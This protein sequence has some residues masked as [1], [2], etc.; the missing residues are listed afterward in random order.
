MQ[1][2]KLD[3]LWLSLSRELPDP[4]GRILQQEAGNTVQ[5]L[6][7]HVLLNR[8]SHRGTPRVVSR[9]EKKTPERLIN[10]IHLPLV[11]TLARRTSYDEVVDDEAHVNRFC[12]RDFAASGGVG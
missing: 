9:E 3:V 4:I 8:L 2:Y 12:G 11:N 6:R 7:G 1:R 5:F 10:C